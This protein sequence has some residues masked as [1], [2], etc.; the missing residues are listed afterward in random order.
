[1]TILLF[2]ACGQ[3][4]IKTP[5]NAMTK[6]EEKRPITKAIPNKGFGSNFKVNAS[7]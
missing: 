4:H 5:K 2:T 6:N 7:N 1:M 3:G